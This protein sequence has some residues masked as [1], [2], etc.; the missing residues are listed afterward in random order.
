MTN[1]ATTGTAA[2]TILRNALAPADVTPMLTAA[3][4]ASA[5]QPAK[6]TAIAAQITIVSVLHQEEEEDLQIL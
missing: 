6:N 3:N 1:V 4:P 2:L 5:T